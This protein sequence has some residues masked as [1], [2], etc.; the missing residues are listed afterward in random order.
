VCRAFAR[1]ATPPAVLYE[2]VLRYPDRDRVVVSETPLEQGM[3]VEL[4]GRTWI[5]VEV[6]RRPIPAPLRFI[7]S[8]D[9]E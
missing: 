5:V 2:I 4:A 3:T 8:M 7:C 1:V 6:V 9:D